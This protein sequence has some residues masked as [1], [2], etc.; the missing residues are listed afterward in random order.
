VRTISTPRTVPCLSPRRDIGGDWRHECPP[1][2]FE[3]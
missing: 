1:F 3:P 2:V